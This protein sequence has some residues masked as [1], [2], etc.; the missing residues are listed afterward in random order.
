MRDPLAPGPAGEFLA[1]HYEDGDD[2]HATALRYYVAWNTRCERHNGYLRHRVE[3]LDARLLLRIADLVGRALE[4]DAAS[5]ALEAV[6]TD[7]HTRYN[8]HRLDWGD[9][10]DGPSKDALLRLSARYGYPV[11]AS[12]PC[13]RAAATAATA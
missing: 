11:P 13:P 4:A 5:R 6:P 1:R 7:F 8:A 2:P 3:D 10:P 9:L 12:E